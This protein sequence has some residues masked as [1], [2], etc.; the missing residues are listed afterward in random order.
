MYVCVTLRGQILGIQTQVF[1][2]GSKHFYSL[3]P[4]LDPSFL[5]SMNVT[6]F[7]SENTS[8]LVQWWVH[9]PSSATQPPARCDVDLSLS[10]PAQAGGLQVC[11]QPRL[12]FLAL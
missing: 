4:L 10:Y 11:R 7:G 2:L 12:L 9:F 3:N 6:L 1:R 5:F 8:F